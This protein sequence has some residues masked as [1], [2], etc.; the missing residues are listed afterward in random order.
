MAKGGVPTPIGPKYENAA[1]IQAAHRNSQNISSR[2]I[3]GRADRGNG[4]PHGRTSQPPAP[5]YLI[6]VIS[7]LH[8]KSAILNQWVTSAFPSASRAITKRHSCAVRIARTG[9]A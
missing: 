1:W 8:P 3:A 2:R 7:Q 6:V 4:I 5:A 9:D